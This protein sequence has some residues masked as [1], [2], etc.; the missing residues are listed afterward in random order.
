MPRPVIINTNAGRG[1]PRPYTMPESAT[2]PPEQRR[3]KSVGEVDFWERLGIAGAAERIAG[4]VTRRD[5]WIEFGKTMLWVVP[6]TALI[7]IWAEREQIAYST[8]VNV[9]IDVQH[10]A[11]DRMVTTLFPLDERI[12]IDVRGPRAS[13]EA[14]RASL[15]AGGNAV[16]ITLS[17]PTS[18]EGE[19]YQLAELI[20][21]NEVFTKNAVDVLKTLPAV[22]IRVEEK[23]S[24]AV[25][26]IV[27]AE[28]KAI[29]SFEFQPATVNIE[30]PKRVIDALRDDQAVVFAEV[31]KFAG[32][33]VGQHEDSVIVH[34]P[35]DVGEVTV[36]PDRVKAKVTIER[37]EEKIIPS[38]PVAIIIPSW[39]LEGPTAASEKIDVELTLTNVSITGPPDAVNSVL[40]D[41]KASVIVSLTN[42][43]WNELRR[44]AKDQPTAEIEVTLTADNYKM[45]PSVTVLNPAQRIKVRM[46]RPQ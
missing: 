9:P 37:V 39:I 26:V 21:R 25:P 34:P 15:A 7:W 10:A 29:G 17:D 1:M 20:G 13:I 44:L 38:I 40:K 22:K 31:S 33:K 24:R 19:I 8:I 6:L 16:V 35:A 14:L 11:P 46:S 36:L 12:S 4:P 45:P 28:D 41:Y 27:R 2:K 32:Q 3:R 5:K 23:V 18:S 30:G 43:Q 42:E